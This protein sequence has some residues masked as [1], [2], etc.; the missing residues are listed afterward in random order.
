MAVQSLWQRTGRTLLTMSVIGITV[1]AIVALEAV[2]RSFTSQFS[3]ML[4]S[5]AEI[6]IRQA[7]ISDTEFSVIDERIGEKLSSMPEVKAVSGIFFTAVML[8]DVKSFFIVWGY[9]PN[10]FGLAFS[11]RQRDYLPITTR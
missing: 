4:G 10:E 9:A 6:M 8:P 5:T 3:D 11:H 2:I 7:N 1:G